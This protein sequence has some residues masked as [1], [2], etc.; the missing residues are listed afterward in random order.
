MNITEQHVS[1]I[2][3]LLGPTPRLCVNSSSYEL[4]E[5]K[6]AVN[7]DIV[8]MT[9][10][11][12]Q[13]LMRKTSGL[14]MSA[15]SHKICLLSRGQRDDVHSRAVV[16]PITHAIQ[17]KLS[18]QFRSLHRDEQI[19]LYKYF[20][21][22][23]ESRKVAGIFYEAIVQ[24]YL[25]EGR[26]LELVP[27]VTLEGT[28]EGTK[29]KRSGQEHQWYSS[30]IIIHNATLDALRQ[31]VSNQLTADIRPNRTLE[32]TDNGMQ[33]VEPD[34]FYVPAITNQKAFDS[35]ILLNGLLYIFQIT[36][37]FK[38][39]INH[40]LIDVAEKYSFPPRDQWRFVFIIPPN[41]TLTVP[42]PRRLA[43]RDLSPYSAVVDVDPLQVL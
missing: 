6:S 34:V 37:G 1:E 22:V 41:M 31:T 8:D 20:E 2:F 40:G 29:R 38:H 4:E 42:L 18:A 17:S 24:L 19:R 25:Q 28:L 7:E 33:S 27:M 12:I 35:F 43:L 39:D 14:S 9:A 23:P 3:D 36:V 5:Y 21:R 26:L 30:H 13:K 15:I 10:S 32:Y 11:E 16:A